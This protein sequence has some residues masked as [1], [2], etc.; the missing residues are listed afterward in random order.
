LFR[1]LVLATAIGAVV[2]AASAFAEN[3]DPSDTQA[4]YA[5][6]ENV[7]WINA[8]PADPNNSGVTVSGMWLTG[9]MWGENIGWINLSCQNNDA[10]FNDICLQA[11]SGYYGVYN[12]GVGELRGYAWG[13]NVGW[14]SFSC[15]NVPATCDS[16]GNYGVT[17]N[18]TTGQFSGFAWGENIG[19]INFGHGEAAA[20]V[21]TGAVNDGDPA[22]PTDLCPFDAG[23]PHVN[24]DGNNT[25]LGLTGQDALGDICD[26]DDDGDGCHDLEE[27]G[28]VPDP[29]P[30]LEPQFGGDRDPLNY[31]DFFDVT[32]DKAVDVADTIQILNR[33]GQPSNVSTNRYDR[34]VGPPGQG[35]RAVEEND[36]IDIGDAVANLQSF[37]HNCAAAPMLG[38]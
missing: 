2:A 35:Y 3:I 5:W 25:A 10:N 28:T 33:F 1:S 27:I 20:R 15:Q 6:G 8:E 13:E 29:D 38:P 7:G 16:T 21:V 32:G 24:T 37:G 31:F 12:N 18:P 34:A 26:P 4:Q 19:W 11:N 30:G 22:F 9:Y 23:G 14:I 17:I 36:G